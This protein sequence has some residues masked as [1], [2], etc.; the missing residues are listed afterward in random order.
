MNALLLMVFNVSSGSQVLRK[1]L[2]SGAN[3]RSFSI[4]V[5]EAHCQM[6][7]TSRKTQDQHHFHFLPA[8]NV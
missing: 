7:Y 3:E 5:D 2:V 1:L 8:V 4:G 6:L